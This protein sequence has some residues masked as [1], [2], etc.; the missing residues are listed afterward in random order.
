MVTINLSTVQTLLF[1]VGPFLIPRLLS[2]YR[3]QRAAAQSTPIPI[4]A[5]PY[6]ARRSLNVLFISTFIAL[7]STLPYFSPENIFAITSSR[8][9]TPNDVL[10]TRLG[11][12][13]P[14]TALTE[15][16]QRLKPRLA[17]LDSRC[18]YLTYGP[19]VLTNC[20]FCNSDEPS[21]YYY[22]ALPSLLLPHLLHLFAL[23]LA[24]S[25]AISGKYGSRWRTSALM[26]GAA[27]LLADCYLVGTHDSKANA[28]VLR[29]EDL[30]LF[31]WRMRTLRG[32]AICVADAALALLLWAASTNR[33][34]AVPPNTAERM[35]AAM[36]VLES[37]RGRLSAVGI[38][39]NVV[40]RD[41][42]LRQ[43][44][45]AYWTQE[46]LVMEEVMA[47][48]EVVDGMQ[49]A[50]GERISVSKVEEE[51]RKFAEGIVVWQEGE[52]VG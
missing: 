41:K 34:F 5:T 19:D 16:D 9:Q 38:V 42:K 14:S 44:G 28:R 31:H 27:F 24:T 3:T 8:L 17:S 21:T 45:D 48:R 43:R 26:L 25:S 40:A 36:K 2:Y 46:G 32:I 37:M 50:L 1:T 51:A 33:I 11:L 29:P 13:R 47:D 4:Q 18:F 15:S 6:V 49:S 10:F 30:D 39:R 23:G 20:P 22:Y 52:G 12:L 35:E 7:I